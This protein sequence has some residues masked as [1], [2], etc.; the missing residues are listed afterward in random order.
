[1]NMTFLLQGK[2]GGWYG[3]TGSWN[4]TTAPVN[5]SRF[6]LL[7]SRAVELAAPR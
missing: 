6:A 7:M 2:D 5:E 3:L 1:M 4:D